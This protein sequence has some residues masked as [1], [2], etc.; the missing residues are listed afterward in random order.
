MG[1]YLGITKDI[2]G[3]KCK[4]VDFLMVREMV[5]KRRKEDHYK[6]HTFNV[7]HICNVK[8]FAIA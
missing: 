2:S 1:T 3:S 8:L 5:H 7:A 4:L 6:W